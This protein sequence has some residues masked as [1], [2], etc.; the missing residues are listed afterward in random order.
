[1]LNSIG[2]VEN[3][4]DPF[5]FSN[6]NGKEVFLIVIYADDSLVIVKEERIQ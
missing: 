4:S 2:F 5:L 6:W 3:K 1:V